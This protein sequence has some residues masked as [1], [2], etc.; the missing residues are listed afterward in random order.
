MLITWDFIMHE[1]RALLI[2]KSIGETI[3]QWNKN[4][5]N[6]SKNRFRKCWCYLIKVLEFWKNKYFLTSSIFFWNIQ[7]KNNIVSLT[8]YGILSRISSPLRGWS[9]MTATSN[10]IHGMLKVMNRN[11]M[12]ARPPHTRYRPRRSPSWPIGVFGEAV[13][14]TRAR[15]LSRHFP[16]WWVCESSWRANDRQRNIYTR[17]RI[18][19]TRYSWACT[20]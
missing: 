11:K 5:F 7:I 19:K 8:M 10:P 18:S 9:M 2:M 16:T 1:Q 15:Y 13:R 12:T 20:D 17:L 14:W 6:V 4:N 3:W